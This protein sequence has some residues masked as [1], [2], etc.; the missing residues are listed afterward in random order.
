MKQLKTI[1]EINAVINSNLA[2]IIFKTMGCGVC[3]AIK[4]RLLTMK[5][6]HPDIPF[7]EAYIEDLPLIRGEYLIFSVPTVI[8][9]SNGKE[10]YRESRF[11]NTYKLNE[12]LLKIKEH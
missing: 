2:L 10:L 3:N 8:V 6:N 5:P 1:D 11:V 9:F 12:F 4:D 7:Y